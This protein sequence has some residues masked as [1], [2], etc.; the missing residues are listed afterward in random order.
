MIV[1]RKQHGSVSVYIRY[2]PLREEEDALLMD[3]NVLRAGSGLRYPPQHNVVQTTIRS[4][5]IQNATDM[6]HPTASDISS[7]TPTAR[8]AV[9]NIKPAAGDLSAIS[10]ASTTSSAKPRPR[11]RPA[12]KGAKAAAA[13]SCISN[14]A[15]SS[16]VSSTIET[17][18]S[19]HPVALPSVIQTFTD[20]SS[21]SHPR[22]PH[23]DTRQ[24]GAP[25]ISPFGSTSSA[26]K[27]TK[28]SVEDE[29]DLYTEDIAD[30]AKLR[31]RS[32]TS[33]QAK[34]PVE[35]I[36]DISSDDDELALLPPF[37][38]RKQVTKRNSPKRRKIAHTSTD[39]ESLR[40]YSEQPTLPVLTSDVS[41][42]LGSPLPPSDPPLPSTATAPISTPPVFGDI[43]PLSSPLPTT[44]RKRKRNPRVSAAGTWDELDEISTADFV[45]ET[46]PTKKSKG[47]SEE[48]RPTIRIP[49][50]GKEKDNDRDGLFVEANVKPKPRRKNKNDGDDDWDAD[51]ESKSSTKAKKRKLDDDDDS[52][53]NGDASAKTKT[54][55][56]PKKK[57]RKAKELQKDGEATADTPKSKKSKVEKAKANGKAKPPTSKEYVDDSDE[58]RDS[59]LMPPPLIP[60]SSRDAGDGTGIVSDSDPAI[61]HTK[62]RS[63]GTGKKVTDSDIP[64][65]HQKAPPR[66]TEDNADKSAIS[67]SKRKGKQRAIVLSDEDEGNAADISASMFNSSPAKEPPPDATEKKERKSQAKSGSSKENDEPAATDNSV[68]AASSSSGLPSTPSASKFSTSN[69]AY[70]IASGRSTPMSELIRKVNSLPGSPFASSKPTYSPYLKSS[71]SALKRIAPLHPNRRTPPPPPPRPPAEEDEETD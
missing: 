12:Y 66:V 20:K 50:A 23:H 10:T 54:K 11:P 15:S 9:V 51:F 16:A 67:T 58:D 4:S 33:A 47:I 21:D 18:I 70:S 42:N 29:I 55:P 32:R 57:G 27:R 17:S 25:A 71:R 62:D 46:Q 13:N 28:V 53:W 7:F 49:A 69:R 63:R 24:D 1:T 38:G 39:I 34:P 35:D 22:S 30:R 36:I 31:S 64:T 19:S 41:L 45:P 40:E 52:D 43:S 3:V 68:L 5:S 65:S 14:V 26:R 37:K 56:P 44:M 48:P 59:R 6:L 2:I 8:A 60:A 61:V